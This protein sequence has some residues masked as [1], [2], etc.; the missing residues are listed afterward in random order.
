MSI[1]Q[2]LSLTLLV[3]LL[4][5]GS[6]MAQQTEKS[7]AYHQRV[8]QDVPQAVLEEIKRQHPDFRLQQKE[9]SVLS[10]KGTKK[11]D[12]QPVNRLE[13]NKIYHVYT[14][15][16]SVNG[17]R[18][19]KKTV[20]NTKGDVIASRQITRNKRVPEQVLITMG[21]EYNGWALTGSRIFITEK[22]GIRTV[23]YNLSLKNGNEEK[24]ILLN[25]QGQIVKNKKVKI[26]PTLSAVMQN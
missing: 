8:D 19:N 9:L 23:F 13:S 18:S 21:R 2:K 14:L 15:S 11:N 7:K 4:I 5:L 12:D 17:I 16:E 26:D 1:M 25:E 22:K 24:N 20:Y 10:K 3:L 6:A